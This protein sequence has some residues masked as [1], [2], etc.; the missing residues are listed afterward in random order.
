MTRY[1]GINDLHLFPKSNL[2][3][4]THRNIKC[5]PLVQALEG[6][7]IF[8][9]S[10]AWRLAGCSSLSRP[11][12]AGPNQENSIVRQTGSSLKVSRE[13]NPFR[14]NGNPNKICQARARVLRQKYEGRGER[15]GKKGEVMGWS[16]G[17][18]ELYIHALFRRIFLQRG[19]NEKR[20][21]KNILPTQEDSV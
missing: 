1:T 2:Y 15:G 17:K 6:R 12:P 11:G 21:W 9:S 3:N 10:S 8:R 16:D 13:D 20:N 5:L 19:V 7:F 14:G 4:N 18:E